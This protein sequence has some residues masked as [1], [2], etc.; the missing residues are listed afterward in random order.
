MKISIPVNFVVQLL[1][2]LESK[3]YEFSFTILPNRPIGFSPVLPTQDRKSSHVPTTD[4][5]GDAGGE[6]RRLS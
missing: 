1:N 2:Q 6:K 4:G 3:L 5:I